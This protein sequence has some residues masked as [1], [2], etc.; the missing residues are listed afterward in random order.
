M[1]DMQT[2]RA[3]PVFKSKLS[4]PIIIHY[5]NRNTGRRVNMFLATGTPEAA[6]E[7]Y[8]KPYIDAYWTVDFNR[9]RTGHC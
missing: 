7:V 2:A 8:R 3:T 9:I 1:M 4:I 5:H 6:C